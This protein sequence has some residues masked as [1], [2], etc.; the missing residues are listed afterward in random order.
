MS[1]A[2]YLTFCMALAA[3]LSIGMGLMAWLDR[4]YFENRRPLTDAGRVRVILFWPVAAPYYWC[5]LHR[6]LNGGW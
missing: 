2:H 1:I 5:W 3:W 6:R 4:L